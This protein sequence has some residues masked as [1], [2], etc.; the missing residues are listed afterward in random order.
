MTSAWQP[1]AL[2]ESSR[3]QSGRNLVLAQWAGSQAGGQ[4]TQATRPRERLRQQES[5]PLPPA[6]RCYCLFPIS[7]L[8]HTNTA[9]PPLSSSPLPSK[10]HHPHPSRS[11]VWFIL[12]TPCIASVSARFRFLSHLSL[13]IN[14]ARHEE[15]ARC[16]GGPCRCRPGR[17]CTQDEASKDPALRAVGELLLYFVNAQLD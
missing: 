1:T 13:L 10:P 2:R 6:A 7:H 9:L 8:L 14:V 4:L 16:R 5:H 17:W 11:E 15:R 12:G 3:P